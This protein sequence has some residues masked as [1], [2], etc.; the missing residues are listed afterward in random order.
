MQIM[1]LNFSHPYHLKE[2]KIG[3]SSLTI[4]C[5]NF[6]WK[7]FPFWCLLCETQAVSAGRG[8]RKKEN[9]CRCSQMSVWRGWGRAAASSVM[10]RSA[11]GHTDQL[12]RERQAG[13]M[14]TVTGRFQVSH[15]IRAHTLSV[16]RKHKVWIISSNATSVLKLRYGS[17][18]IGINI[19]LSLKFWI[20]SSSYFQGFKISIIHWKPWA[21]PPLFGK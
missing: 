9:L 21:P 2:S 11:N 8:T 1:S 18:S 19:I 4:N 10:G 12:N 5:H 16:L 6:P 20:I 14:N 13:A 3:R 15:V 7:Q 17:K